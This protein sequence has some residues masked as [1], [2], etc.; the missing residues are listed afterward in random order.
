IPIVFT[1]SNWDVAVPVVENAL[2]DDDRVDAIA[3]FEVRS[4][5]LATVSELVT[6]TDTTPDPNTV[7]LTF[8]RVTDAAGNVS[9]SANAVA[10]VSY[11]LQTSA[12]FVNWTDVE[13]KVADSGTITFTA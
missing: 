9:L 10:G 2:T 8:E 3:T 11:I 4:D 6:Q 12:D 7:P 13:T 5:G 1:P